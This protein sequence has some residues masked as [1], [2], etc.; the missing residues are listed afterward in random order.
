MVFKGSFTNDNYSS[1]IH[2]L[3][4][5]FSQVTSKS[6]KFEVKTRSAAEKINKIDFTNYYGL[7]PQQ[8]FLLIFFSW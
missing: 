4:F 6:K 3:N 1:G 8:V 7:K 5:F 2:C